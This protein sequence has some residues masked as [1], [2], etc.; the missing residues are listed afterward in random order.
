MAVLSYS[1]SNERIDIPEEVAGDPSGTM[2]L[3]VVCEYKRMVEQVIYRM[4]DLEPTK[5]PSAVDLVGTFNSIK[6]EPEK[7][8]SITQT[9]AVH[10]LCGTITASDRPRL[11]IAKGPLGIEFTPE[12]PSAI[13]DYRMVSYAIPAPLVVNDRRFRVSRVVIRFDTGSKGYLREVEVRD[14]SKQLVKFEGLR[15]CGKSQEAAWDIPG[16]PEMWRGVA[17]FIGWGFDKKG[18]DKEYV[19]SEARFRIES[20]AVEMNL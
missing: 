17:I 2:L 8:P 1:V 13:N 10:G 11:Q 3:P 16:N 14:G 12:R 18:F 15:L 4:L 7:E 6:S 20:V 5:R 19:V 9:Y